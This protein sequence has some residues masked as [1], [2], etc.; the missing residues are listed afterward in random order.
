MLEKH[1]S[2][3]SL[4][5]YRLDIY[6]I[7][8]S[9]KLSTEQ[10][11]HRKSQSWDKN[12]YELF[13]SSFSNSLDR[14]DES[15]KYEKCCLWSFKSQNPIS[16]H[17]LSLSN[18]KRKYFFQVRSCN[19]RSRKS[20]ILI[21]N[22]LWIC[23]ELCSCFADLFLFLENSSKRWKWF[24]IPLVCFYDDESWDESSGRL[25]RS[26]M[27]KFFCLKFSKLLTQ[28]WWKFSMLTK[29]SILL[30]HRVEFSYETAAE[31]VNDF[32][33]NFTL[34]LHRKISVVK[35]THDVLEVRRNKTQMGHAWLKMKTKGKERKF[36][37]VMKNKVSR[38]GM[39]EEGEED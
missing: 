36:C 1:F 20:E 6:Y 7:F 8:M 34:K 3:F 22:R 30:R 27:I 19:H 33:A 37:C 2:Q 9:C 17:K 18:I 15:W 23:W 35:N 14:W 29:F 11:F 38:V 16:I 26:N 39:S 10:R 24:L 13:C 21:P 32:A 4:K 5:T 28:V 12:F 31:N 25:R